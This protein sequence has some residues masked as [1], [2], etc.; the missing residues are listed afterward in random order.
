MRA[1]ERLDDSQESLRLAIEGQLSNLWTAIPA[2][3]QNV[4]YAKQTLT[5]Q[6]AIMAEVTDQKQNVSTVKLPLLVDVPFQVYGG[7]GFVVTMPNLEGS[8][9]LIVFASRCIDSW[10]Q[11]GGVQKQAEHRMH[12]L[13]DGFAVLGFRSQPQKVTS[14]NTSAMELRTLDGATKIAISSS[15]VD[16]TSGYLKHNGKNIGATHTHS[17]VTSGTSNTGVPV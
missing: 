11:S 4:D 15:G 7:S 16:I 5:A 3:I 9:C 6:P 1:E 13:S 2:I 12:D 17:G 10:W 8:E 14:Y